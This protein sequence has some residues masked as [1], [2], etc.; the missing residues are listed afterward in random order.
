MKSGQ[1]HIRAPF[2]TITS[3]NNVTAPHRKC[4]KSQ[5]IGSTF[6]DC[7]SN[8]Q[9]TLSCLNAL[10][11]P[12]SSRLVHLVRPVLV[13]AEAFEKIL[14]AALCLLAELAWKQDLDALG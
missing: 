14:K 4:S 2:F 8:S 3:I 9:L 10:F 7:L 13:V 1:P 12:W 6:A 5:R 11:S